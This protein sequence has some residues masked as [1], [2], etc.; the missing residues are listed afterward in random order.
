M[1]TKDE[2]RQIGGDHMTFKEENT[3]LLIRELTRRLATRSV[4]KNQEYKLTILD[5]DK[6]L[7]TP[8]IAVYPNIH[9]RKEEDLDNVLCCS[10]SKLFPFNHGIDINEETDDW[11]ICERI[12]ED[13]PKFESGVWIYKFSSSK[14]SRRW[15]KI[16]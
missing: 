6:I 9:R 2:D 13:E 7:F 14:K 8:N 16:G 1:F 10:L 4:V 11:D 5:G 12:F 15:E 3:Y